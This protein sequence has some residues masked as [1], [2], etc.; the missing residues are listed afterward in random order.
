VGLGVGATL[1]MALWDGMQPAP[2]LQ[3]DMALLRIV[4]RPRVG[5]LCPGG[6]GV[7][8]ELG[9]MPPRAASGG[10]GGGIGR[11]AAPGAQA[12]QQTDRCVGQRQ[13][14]LDGVVASGKADA[15]QRR[16][17]MGR[18]ALGMADGDTWPSQER[19][20]S[21]AT[22]LAFSP[23]RIRRI[24]RIRNGAVQLEQREGTWTSQE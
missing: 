23:G 3:L 16:A 17:T 2:G 19:I 10:L 24:R 15:G 6:R 13:A 5:R 1:G 22:R 4:A 9:P 18:D 12:H 20:C 11:E 14:E 7:A 8:D 21:A